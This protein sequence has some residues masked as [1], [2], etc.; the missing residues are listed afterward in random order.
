MYEKMGWFYERIYFPSTL[1]RPQENFTARREKPGERA[2]SLCASWEWRV[3]T[4]PCAGLLSLFTPQSGK[5]ARV[6]TEKTSPNPESFLSTSLS[7]SHFVRE[8]TEITTVPL[9]V[10]T[11]IYWE[12]NL[13]LD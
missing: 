3:W 7:L 12:L 13:Y 10:D 9:I 5:Q 4:L 1:K 2:S 8:A 11:K 6:H